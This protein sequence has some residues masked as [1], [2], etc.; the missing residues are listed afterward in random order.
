VIIIVPASLLFCPSSISFFRFPFPIPYT[1]TLQWL[2]HHPQYGRCY[3]APP[4]IFPFIPFLNHPTEEGKMPL[5]Y[6]AFVDAK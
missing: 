2:Y 5:G 3:I 4:P 1:A 6:A